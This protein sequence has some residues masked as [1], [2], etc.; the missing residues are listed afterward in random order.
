ML[1]HPRSIL[2]VA[3]E[4]VPFSKSGGLADVAGALPLALARL[5]HRVTLVV[6]RYATA[7]ATSR[8]DRAVVNMGGRP[9]GVG[10]IEQPLADGATAVLVDCPE[11][12]GREGLYGVGSR[13]YADNA[14]RF[15]VLARAALEWAIRAGQRIDLIHAHDWQA[16]L[17][18]VYLKTH[19]RDHPVFAGAGSVFTIHNLAY[20]GLFPPEWLAELDLGWELFTI[21]GLEY[22]GSSRC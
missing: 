6:P 5:G 19:Y 8:A 3:S 7:E 12:Y 1:L 16:G 11:L 4:A 10:F 20:Q 14:R 13:D 15:A 21:E 2:M 22:W 18:P 9:I 17:A